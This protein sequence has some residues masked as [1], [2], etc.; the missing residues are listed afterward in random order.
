MLPVT[1]GNLPAMIVTGN[2]KNNSYHS[3]FGRSALMDVG[4]N[5]GEPQ[6]LESSLERGQHFQSQGQRSSMPRLRSNDLEAKVDA[7]DLCDEG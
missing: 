1:Y 6:I 7:S 3:E 4:V 5:T 2:L